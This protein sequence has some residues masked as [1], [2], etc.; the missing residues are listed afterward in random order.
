M[1]ANTPLQCRGQP[2][3]QALS[4]HQNV[5]GPEGETPEPGSTRRD[6]SKVMGCTLP[7][8]GLLGLNIAKFPGSQE[9]S[10]D[11]GMACLR[12]YIQS[13]A[14]NTNSQVFQIGGSAKGRFPA[15]FTK[16]HSICLGKKS[17][18][19]GTHSSIL[20]PT[21]GLIWGLTRPQK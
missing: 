9:S 8:S 18:G 2:P 20:P 6:G 3:Q 12:I 10:R 15:G 21:K 17:T 4:Y 7:S 5:S 1:L 19:G 14:S 11:R 16:P 13:T